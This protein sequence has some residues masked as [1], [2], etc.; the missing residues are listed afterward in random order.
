VTE[1]RATSAVRT[2]ANSEIVTEMPSTRKTVGITKLP[3]RSQLAN[4]TSP[5]TGSPSTPA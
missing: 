5:R 1:K 4:S 3:M 2:A